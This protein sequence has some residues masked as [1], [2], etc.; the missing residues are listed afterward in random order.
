MNGTKGIQSSINRD[1]G[2]LRFRR[3]KGS[4]VRGSLASSQGGGDS[5]KRDMGSGRARA[6]I[7]SGRTATGERAA[8][9]N[10]K[11]IQ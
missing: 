9:G 3:E 11:T 8:A 10:K 1:I 6:E 5:I 4:Q 2:R 7:F